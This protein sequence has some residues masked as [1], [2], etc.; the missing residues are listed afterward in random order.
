[1]QL[2]RGYNQGHPKIWDKNLIYI[3]HSYNRA[4]HAST[5]Q[6]PFETCFGYFPPSLLDVVYGEKGG[7][8]EDLTGDA[9]RAEKIVEK[10]RQIHLQVQELFKKSQ[11]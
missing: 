9:L 10:I 1:M 7:V 3:Q 11:E 4:I 6:S 2:L 8:R 5:G